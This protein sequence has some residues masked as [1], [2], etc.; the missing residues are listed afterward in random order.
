MSNY[1]FSEDAPD[2][3]KDAARDLTRFKRY[4]NAAGLSGHAVL[5]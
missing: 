1:F 4:L 5:R 3:L 2:A